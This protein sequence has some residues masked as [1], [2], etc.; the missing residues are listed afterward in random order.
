[1]IKHLSKLRLSETPTTMIKHLSKLRLSETPT[2]M[3]KHLSKLRLSETPPSFSSSVAD[4]TNVAS[5]TPLSPPLTLC[6]VI[7]YI[8]SA[9]LSILL[10][11]TALPI[12]LEQPEQ[13][14]VELTEEEFDTSAEEKN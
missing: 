12:Q 2:T 7:A 9:I 3:I 13:T 1:M 6:A 8:S 10:Y 4:F 11:H 14:P 5:L